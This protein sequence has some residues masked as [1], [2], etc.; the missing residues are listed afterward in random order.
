MAFAN[1]PAERHH[2]ARR[3]SSEASIIQSEMM[4]RL[5]LSQPKRKRAEWVMSLT[6]TIAH[7]F[8]GGSQLKA[9][10]NAGQLANLRPSTSVNKNR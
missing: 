1:V 7:Q 8:C 4:K 3:E 5:T 9:F 6:L 10:F 2:M